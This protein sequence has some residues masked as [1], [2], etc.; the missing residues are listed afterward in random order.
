MI[1]APPR[2][3]EASQSLLETSKSVEEIASY[4]DADIVEDDC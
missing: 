1:I 2:F 3:L 4:I